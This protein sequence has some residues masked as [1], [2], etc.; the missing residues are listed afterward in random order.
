MPHARSSRPNHN[1]RPGTSGR[2][3]WRLLGLISFLGYKTVHHSAAT[4]SLSAETLLY[5]DGLRDEPGGLPALRNAETTL[6]GPHGGAGAGISSASSRIKFKAPSATHENTGPSSKLTWLRPCLEV[7]GER[8]SEIRGTL[9][10]TD[11][12]ETKPCHRESHAMCG[13][14]RAL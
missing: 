12:P 5:R 7:E 11:V 9:R 4:G 8:H 6:L 2:L 10:G 14:Q 1:H 3:A 13:R